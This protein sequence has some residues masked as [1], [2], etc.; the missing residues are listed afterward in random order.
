MYMAKKLLSILLS[1]A[2][3]WASSGPTT[4]WAAVNAGPNSRLWKFFPLLPVPLTPADFQR[5]FLDLSVEWQSQYIPAY[6]DYIREN[7]NV[8]NQPAWEGFKEAKGILAEFSKRSG[9]SRPSPEQARKDSERLVLA[10][11]FPNAQADYKSDPVVPLKTD[12]D[13]LSVLAGMEEHIPDLFKEAAV[14][15][16]DLFHLLA[17]QE[18]LERRLVRMPSYR[19]LARH[20]PP[21]LRIEVTASKDQKVVEKRIDPKVLQ[22]WRTGLAETLTALPAGERGTQL[23]QALQEKLASVSRFSAND[24][25]T[26]LINTLPSAKRLEI[27]GSRKEAGQGLGLQGVLKILEKELPEELVSHGFKASLYGVKADRLEKKEAL[28]LLETQLAMSQ[29]LV[30]LTA[31]HMLV[32]DP[33]GRV[34]GTQEELLARIE[35]AGEAELDLFVDPKSAAERLGRLLLSCGI[36]AS[37]KM[38]AALLKP[39]QKQVKGILS[40]LVDHAAEISGTVV[41]QE[42]RPLIGIFSGFAGGD[43]SSQYSAAYSNSPMERKF[44]VYGAEKNLKGYVA[45]TSVAALR[46][47]ASYLHT[48]NGRKISAGDVQLILHGLREALG[49]LILP[50]PEQLHGFINFSQIESALKPLVTG[51]LLASLYYLDGGVRK[52]LDAEARKALE[53]EIREELGAEV[54]RKLEP[55]ARKA[56]EIEVKKNLDAFDIDYDKAETNQ[57]GVEFVSKTLSGISVKVQSVLP[58]SFMAKKLSPEQVWRLALDLEYADRADQAHRVMKAASVRND[59]AHAVSVLKNVTGLPVDQYVLGIDETF[60]PAGL[61]KNLELLK[62]QY[63]NWFYQGW[64]RAPDAMSAKWEDATLRYLREMPKQEPGWAQAKEL[65]W[66]Y[67]EKSKKL[68][69]WLVDLFLEGVKDATRQNVQREE[70]RALAM[71]GILKHVRGA[72]DSAVLSLE[73]LAQRRRGLVFLYEDSGIVDIRPDD[74]RVSEALVAGLRDKSSALETM[75]FIRRRGFASPEVIAALEE[76]LNGS[77]QA[78]RNGAAITLAKIHVRNERIEERLFQIVQSMDSW[79]GEGPLVGAEAADALRNWGT[80][81]EIPVLDVLK[82]MPQDGRGWGYAVKFIQK[83]GAKI[84]KSK[85]LKS[86]VVSLYLAAVKAKDLHGGW[87]IKFSSIA[88]T[89]VL[90]YIRKEFTSAIL[91]I[92][93]ALQRCVQ[94]TFQD[95]EVLSKDVLRADAQRVSEAVLAG[96]KVRISGQPTM[97]FIR[98]EKFLSPEIVAA[99]QKLL[100]VP[101]DM[102][103]RSWAAITLAQN[104]IREQGDEERLFEIIQATARWAS[105]SRAGDLVL[106]IE[107]AKALRNLGLSKEQA[108]S[109]FN[110]R[111]PGVSESAFSLPN[112]GE[113]EELMALSLLCAVSNKDEEVLEKIRRYADYAKGAARLEASLALI[114]Q[115]SPSENEHVALVRLVRSI[116]LFFGRHITMPEKVDVIERLGELAP[117]NPLALKALRELLKRVGDDLTLRSAIKTALANIEW[118]KPAR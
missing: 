86:W 12:A 116:D 73:D 46:A 37:E 1:A 64:L 88:E 20:A 77:E 25:L 99:L 13:K 44:L 38:K 92:E 30:K 98:R 22:E 109:F 26:G 47:L 112:Y 10:L 48:I 40:T 63:P 55:E 82:K 9:N 62:H 102:E 53:R 3:V 79:V 76:R 84:E 75:H 2:L 8:L 56:L 42:V 19:E 100:K 15:D 94:L 74:P 50:A 90:K 91:S 71:P 4:L 80:K 108:L 54:G 89:G 67:V 45:L 72:L 18:K 23:R 59:L 103:T 110:R 95:E 115:N 68:K 34:Q 43:C 51:K 69:N 6:G 105:P 58:Q 49:T 66:T 97:A 21:L 60:I 111:Y 85:T 36:Q 28:R 52:V 93:D 14:Y 65:I 33:E 81:W 101:T 114:E 11:F 118:K 70:F 117:K 83:Q 41:L 107:A 5:T 113:A 78:V 106:G 87:G 24:F 104:G 31:L 32:Q 61:N 27:Q 35:R 29:D 17:N 57:H 7:P 96:L 16:E 39:V